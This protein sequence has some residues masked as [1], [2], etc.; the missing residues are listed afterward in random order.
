MKIMTFHLDEE[1]YAVELSAVAAV[2]RGGAGAGT[3]GR[4]LAGGG[5]AGA[6][7]GAAAG[8]SGADE[9]GCGAAGAT[10][11][12]AAAFDIAGALGL[13]AG[14]GAGAAEGAVLVLTGQGGREVEVRVGQLGEVA[15]VGGEGVRGV[16][17]YFDSPLLRGV[18][19]VGDGWAVL[20]DAGAVVRAATAG[21]VPAAGGG[22]EGS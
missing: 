16:P 4:A 19:R 2:A 11:D 17:R 6:G 20:L 9:D 5:A 8:A 7:A 3:G 22:E 18:V 10:G 13:G 21:V 1:T 15:E 12:A 14:E